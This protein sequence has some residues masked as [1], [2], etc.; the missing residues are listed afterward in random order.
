MV[1]LSPATLSQMKCR[2]PVRPVGAC[3]N[4]VRLLFNADK[5]GGTNGYKIFLSMSRTKMSGEGVTVTPSPDILVRLI[6]KI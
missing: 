6:L 1:H 4:K 5:Q 2:K 3:Q